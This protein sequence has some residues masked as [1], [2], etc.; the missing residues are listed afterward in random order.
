MK[1]LLILA[2]IFV[3]TFSACG[4]TSTTETKSEPEQT[5]TSETA[6]PLKESPATETKEA[7][8]EE[9]EGAI[10]DYQVKIVTAEMGKDYQDKDAVIITY[11]F[12]NNSDKPKSFVVSVKDSVFQAGVECSDAMMV[13][14]VETENQLKEIK[15]G[16]PFELKI[17]YVLNDLESPVEVECQEAITFDK[18]P[19]KVT[20]T[21]DLPLA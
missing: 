11:E 12:I 8:N 19:P 1:K 21:F 4:S 5:E 9:P 3:L 20:K 7:V 10:G 13:E 2:L 6:E 14:G 17:A 15:P 18:E 16:T